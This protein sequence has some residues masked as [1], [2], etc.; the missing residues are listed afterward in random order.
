MDSHAH[1]L[2]QNWGETPTSYPND[3]AGQ[4]RLARGENR[5]IL[6]AHY[7][8]RAREMITVARYG[9]RYWAV[10]LDGELVVVALYKKGAASVA[11]KLRELLV[12]KGS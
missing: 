2:A 9:T 6:D 8:S 12:L 11:A 10:W 7:R 3:N 1:W 4:T 5:A